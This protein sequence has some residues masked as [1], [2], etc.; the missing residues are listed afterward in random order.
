M[1]RKP[2]RAALDENLTGRPQ[3]SSLAALMMGLGFIHLGF[4]AAG[5]GGGRADRDPFAVSAAGAASRDRAR[6]TS[7]GSCSAIK[8]GAGS[9]GAGSCWPCES[10]VCFLLALLFAR[11]FWRA[12]ETLGQRARGRDPD[13][14]LGEHGRREPRGASP[15]DKAQ[16]QAAELDRAACPM[17]PRSAWRISIPRSVAPAPEAKIDPAIRPGLAGTDYTKALGWARDIVVASRRL[18]RQVF[19]LH[20]S[21]ALRRWRSPWPT[22][23]RPTWKSS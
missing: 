7:C 13:R 22:A 12:P 3:P 23:F 21:S 4:L 9:S 10:P 14:S 11:P 1:F 17:G 19:L 16:R 5:R 20:R 8:L 6:S 18:K 15:F 2:A